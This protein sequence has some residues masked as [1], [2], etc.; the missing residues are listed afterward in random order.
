VR[1]QEKVTDGTSLT[2]RKRLVV[3]VC[4]AVLVVVLVGGVVAFVALKREPVRIGNPKGRSTA[5]SPVKSNE[6]DV[7]VELE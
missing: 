3:S 7:V 5:A 1:S 6:V 4:A 2:G